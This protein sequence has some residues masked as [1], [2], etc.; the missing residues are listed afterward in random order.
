[1]ATT[2][3]RNRHSESGKMRGVDSGIEIKYTKANAPLYILK[4][5]ADLQPLASEG[6]TF[7]DRCRSE[8]CVVK[9]NLKS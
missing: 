2:P 6:R 5:G 7:S 1:M 8:C 9:Q 4:W 3:I